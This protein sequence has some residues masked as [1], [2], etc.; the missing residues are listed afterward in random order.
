LGSSD[1]WDEAKHDL[2][3]IGAVLILK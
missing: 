2:L 1:V 3:E